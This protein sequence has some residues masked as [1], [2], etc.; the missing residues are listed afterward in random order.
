MTTRILRRKSV[1]ERTGLS[2]SGIY[3]KMGEDEFPKPVNLGGRNVGWI[4][5]EIE[6]WIEQCIASSRT[7]VDPK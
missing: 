7:D 6:T 4:E 1:E 5:A 2:R 3:K